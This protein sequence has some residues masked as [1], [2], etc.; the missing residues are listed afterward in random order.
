MDLALR[1]HDYLAMNVKYVNDGSP[2]Q[3]SMMGPLLLGKGVCEGIAFTYSYIMGVFGVN[4]S[5]V[6]GQLKGHIDGHAWNILFLGGRAYHVDVTHD[7]AGDNPMCLHLHMNQTDE[8]MRVDRSWYFPVKCDDTLYNYYEYTGSQMTTFK[9][10]CD[11][12]HDCIEADQ[13]VVEFRIRPAPPS[14]AVFKKIDEYISS[15]TDSA[16]Y[17][18]YRVE[19]VYCIVF[20]SVHFRRSSGSFRK[21]LKKLLNT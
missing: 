11:Y 8:E 13:K 18:W 5:T 19:D 1:V 2:E 12:L 17:R 4:C 7:L 6:Y 3:Q 10:V 21:G 16:S 14:D 9:E 20:E 15:I